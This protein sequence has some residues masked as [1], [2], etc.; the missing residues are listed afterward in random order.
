[1]ARMPRM[2]NPDLVHTRL[3]GLGFG[4]DK[5]CETQAYKGCRSLLPC[6]IV[7][8]TA[9]SM[10]HHVWDSLNLWTS[11]V[12]PEPISNWWE[13]H[14]PHKTSFWEIKPIL[15]INLWHCEGKKATKPIARI[16]WWTLIRPEQLLQWHV[17]HHKDTKE[18][19]FRNSLIVQVA[20]TE[21][22]PRAR[23]CAKCF[24]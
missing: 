24:R 17:A 18:S 3:T 11:A 9:G 21:C 1:M 23:N 7:R 20:V 15:P 19:H 13:F 10:G 8:H 14:I 5:P 4:E 2:R 6:V 16:Q 22:L 12:V